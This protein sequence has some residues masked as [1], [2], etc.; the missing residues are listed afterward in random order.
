MTRVPLFSSPF[1]LGFDQLE[2][3]LER[4]SKTAG[5]GYPP[6]NIEQLNSDHLR[7]SLAVAG[8]TRDDL[9]ITVENTQL[10]IRG[11]QAP[12]DA[13][14]IFLH[15]GI[16]AR[17]FQRSFVL[18]EGIEV[19]GAELNDGMLNIELVRPIPSSRQRVIEIRTGNESPRTA[20]RSVEGGAKA[21]AT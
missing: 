3:A 2:Q 11:R 4:I 15:R 19:T 5:D 1:L 6:Y 16:A 9:T 10:T 13:N 8:F 14:K 17:Q 20:F 7:I 18:A 12:D 21:K